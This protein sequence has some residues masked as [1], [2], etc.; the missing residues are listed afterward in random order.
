ME[1]IIYMVVERY[2][3]AFKRFVRQQALFYCSLSTK[4]YFIA[5][6]VQRI[7]VLFYDTIKQKL[8]RRTCES[9][10]RS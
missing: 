5:G 3:H 2:N 6:I 7:G 1:V 9:Y 4:Y 8:C 10:A